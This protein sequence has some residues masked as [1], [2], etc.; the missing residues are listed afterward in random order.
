[1]KIL[2]CDNCLV[3]PVCIRKKSI[4]LIED[5][6]I[7]RDYI[8]V[9]SKILSPVDLHKP[10]WVFGK[11]RYTLE[12]L[13]THMD[14]SSLMVVFRHSSMKYGINSSYALS[15]GQVTCVLYPDKIEVLRKECRYDN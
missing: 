2:P 9:K 11:H 13:G 3:Q 1:M 10:V 14:G 6:T 15:V 4:K 7:L 5:C 12:T 8:V